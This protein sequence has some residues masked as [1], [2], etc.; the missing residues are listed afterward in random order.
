[1]EKIFQGKT[2]LVT[3][4]G[5]KGGIGMAVAQALAERGC[6]IF[7]SYFYSDGEKMEL[8]SILEELRTYGGKVDGREIDLSHP[9]SAE[10]VFSNALQEFGKI[11]ILVNNA[12]CSEHDS[13]ESLSSDAIDRHYFVN[14]RTPMLLVGEFSRSFKG[15]SGGRIINLT[16]GRALTPMPDELAYV[17]SKAA[18]DAFMQSVASTL[19]RQG[20]TINSVDPG[21]TD[22]GWMVGGL[23]EEF[24]KIAPLGRVGTPEDVA[25]LVVF[26]A[27]E[28]ARYITGQVIRSR[29]GV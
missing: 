20:I 29:G 17:A 13:L 5:R 6:N 11:N 28:E 27:S 25:R 14:V 18:M 2:A 22:T 12:A 15:E 4:L 9:Q 8:E 3:G 23:R 24:A 19:M 26:L 10:K 16:S 7:F 21:A 1:M